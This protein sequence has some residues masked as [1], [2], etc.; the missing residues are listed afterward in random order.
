MFKKLFVF[1]LLLTLLIAPASA[2]DDMFGIPGERLIQLGDA[3]AASGEKDQFAFTY[4]VSLSVVV[5]GV[6]VTA[7]LSG[8]GA[9]DVVNE[10]A[11]LTINGTASAGGAAPTALEGELRIIGS[12]LFVRGTD[13]TSGQDSGWFSVN[14]DELEDQNVNFDSFGED[15]AD[16]FL[17]GFASGAG[18]DANDL[19]PEGMLNAF[20]ALASLDPETFIGMTLTDGPIATY[21]VNISLSDL[22]AQPAMLDVAREFLRASA[23]ATEITDAELSEF[24]RLVQQALAQTAIVFSERINTQSGL[25]DGANISIDSTIDPA[26]IGETGTPII[27]QFG[28]DVTLTS[29]DQ[30]ANL[31]TPANVTALPASLVVSSLGLPTGSSSS[32]SG[33]TASTAAAGAPVSLSGSF[34]TEAIA[35]GAEVAYPIDGS[36]VVT[37]TARGV[38]SGVDP[39]I[40]VRD[41]SGAELA[42]NDDHTTGNSDLNF[43]DAVVENVNIPSGSTLIIRNTTFG[44]EGTIEVTFSGGSASSVPLGDVQAATCT[45]AARDFASNIGDSVSVSC[46]SGCLTDGGSVWGTDVYTD[47]SSVCAA[48]IHAGAIG[49]GGG[50]VN[51][52][53]VAGLSDHPASDRN[54]VSTSSWGSWEKSFSFNGATSAAPATVTGVAV[55][56][57]DR[58]QD[59]STDN[60]AVLN[61][62]CP[63][64]C[65]TGGGSIWGTDVYTSD[66]SICTAAVHAGVITDAGGNATLTIVPGLSEHPGSDRNGVS[67]SSWGSWDQAFSFGAASSAAPSSSSFANSYTFGTGMTMGYPNGWTFDDSGAP[68]LVLLS[69]PNTLRAYIQVFDD[70]SLFGVG[71]TAALGL[72]QMKNIYGT[73][74]TSTWRADVGVADFEEV[75]LNGRTL[76]VL[77]FEGT[78]N[79][80]PVIGSV[81]IVELPNGDFT[82]VIAYALQ[83]YPADF[84]N[85]VRSIAASLTL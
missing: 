70:V 36:G 69:D 27:V 78:Q 33:S 57:F 77:E 45:S 60:G 2:Q 55:T 84:L 79:D 85:V 34:V 22:F 3:I 42:T 56:C 48:A 35:S 11:S 75:S 41:S 49:D 59:L 72:D 82:H 81:I 58:A 74:P 13:P 67:S 37:I 66:S 50:V 10:Q 24:N 26:S 19:D 40:T 16:E 83:P 46:P 63:S 20:G 39:Q 76:H 54:G 5:E 4:D 8:T 9:L 64:G 53:I 30:A 23:I 32:D 29:Y 25:V 51:F 71:G 18:V 1:V 14:L 6:N 61:V 12:D 7:A 17:G 38:E 44:T 68:T 21:T 15:L 80:E 73:T 28:L 62:A 31:E 65:A 43:L 47:D 52:S